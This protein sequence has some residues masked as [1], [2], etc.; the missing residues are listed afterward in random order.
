MPSDPV[1]AGQA[2]YSPR[3]LRMYDWLV[4][5][6]S[7]RFIWRCPA[8][9]LKRLYAEHLTGNHLDVGVGTGYFLDRCPFPTESPRVALMDLNAH[10]LQAAAAR[11]ARYEPVLLTRNILEPIPFDGAPFTSIGLNYV[12]HC[13]PGS[14]SEKGV[15]FDHLRPLLAPGGV[16]FGSTLLSAGV[17]SNLVA[18]RLMAAYNGK[19]IFSNTADS[20]DDLRSALETRFAEWSVETVGCVA[21]FTAKRML[22]KP[23]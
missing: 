5:G 18:R 8:R 11:I 22:G 14:I 16:L 19:Q 9:H 23:G 4:L 20:L 7:N 1:A 21:L 6:L 12:L 10:C 15:V 17:H 3:V 13:L 2:V